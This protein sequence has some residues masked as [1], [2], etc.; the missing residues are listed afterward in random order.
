MRAASTIRHSLGAAGEAL[1][2]ALIVAV[3][4]LALAPIYRPADWLAGDADAGRAGH[5]SVPDG[6]FGGRTTATVNPGGADV[7][8]HARCYQDGALVFE[9]Y[10][11]VNAEDQATFVLG[12]TPSWSGG[13]A[14]CEAEEGYWHRGTRW[15]VVADT[16]FRVYD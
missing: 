3:L 1:L 13:G 12:P 7:W 8:A 4:A 6:V 15:R 9:Q 10:V 16:T 11:R 14:S 2:I 5:I